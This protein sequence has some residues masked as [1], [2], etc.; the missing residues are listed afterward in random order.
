MYTP[1]LP[2]LAADRIARRRA[3]ADRY[4]LVRTVRRRKHRQ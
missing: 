3:E 1:F 2:E 4:R